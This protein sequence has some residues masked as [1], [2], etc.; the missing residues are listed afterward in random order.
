M[1][2]YHDFE[3]IYCSRTAMGI[4]KFGHDNIRLMKWKAYYD[5]YHEIMN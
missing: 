2:K 4:Y 1:I 5:R 3:Q